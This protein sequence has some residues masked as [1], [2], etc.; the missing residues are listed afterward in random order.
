MM[1]FEI[2]QELKADT[3]AQRV[4]ILEAM[5]DC[6]KI[7]FI[8]ETNKTKEEYIKHLSEKFGNVLNITKETHNG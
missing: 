8:V 6:G 5:A 7:G 3:E 1:F 2:C 4:A